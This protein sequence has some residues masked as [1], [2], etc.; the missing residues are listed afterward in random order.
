MGSA[1]TR[2][3][4][5]PDLDRVVVDAL[6]AGDASAFRDLVR[7]H[8]AAMVAV[9][10]RYVHDR[11]VAEDVV[12]ETWL[13]LIE[14]LDRF[15]GRS[16]LKTWL[17]TV[18]SNRARTHWRRQTRVVPGL[19]DG[20]WAAV[21]PDRFRG[22]HDR[23]PGHWARPPVDW[24]V[25]AART[26]AGELRDVIHRA[27]RQLPAGQAAVITLRD[28]EGW[29]AT[30]VCAALDLSPGNQRVLLHRARSRVRSALDPYLG[31]GG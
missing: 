4:P 3:M 2:P 27:I 15:E 28:V 7:R 26:E 29:T 5:S 25:P 10:L 14:R 9:A 17:F 11:Q 16:S 31:D 18:L 22:P 19:E 8:H 24:D 30:E 20:G 21:D 23:W 1:T 12:Q 6:R 13:A